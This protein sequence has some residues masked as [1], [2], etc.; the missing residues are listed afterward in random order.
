MA[1]MQMSLSIYFKVS[2]FSIASSLMA[3]LVVQLVKCLPAMRETWVKS[4]GWEDPWEKETAA[5]SSILAWKI[6]R[7]EERGRL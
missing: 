5:H 2:F 4:L 7:M 3:F 1:Q 6:P